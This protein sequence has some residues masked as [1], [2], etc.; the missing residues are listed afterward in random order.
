[1]ALTQ[2]WASESMNHQ[3]RREAE[4]ERLRQETH[5]LREELRIKDVRMQQ[6]AFPRS[7]TRQN[8]LYGFG[9]PLQRSW[10]WVLLQRRENWSSEIR[11]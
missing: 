3:L 11:V 7:G 6:L 4:G 10:G 8:D 2:G 9:G 5:L 1:L